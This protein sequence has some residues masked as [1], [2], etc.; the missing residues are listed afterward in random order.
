MF[1]L[2]AAEQYCSY[3]TQ[4]SHINHCSESKKPLHLKAEVQQ[5]VGRVG[6]MER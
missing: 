2:H 1:N 6:V 5:G 4:L 3:I